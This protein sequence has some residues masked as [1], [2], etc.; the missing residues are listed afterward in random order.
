[1]ESY[2]GGVTLPQAMYRLVSE[3]ALP[4]TAPMYRRLS[5]QLAM[6]HRGEL[7]PPT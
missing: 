6:A 4:H 1:M 2:E 3:G 5:A 7:L